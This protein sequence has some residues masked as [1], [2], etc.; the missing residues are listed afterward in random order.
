VPMTTVVVRLTSNTE[1]T[2]SDQLTLLLILWYP[3]PIKMTATIQLK[4][5]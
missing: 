4:Y 2:L 1:T 3:P 5:C